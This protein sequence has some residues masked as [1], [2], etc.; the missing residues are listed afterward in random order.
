MLKDKKNSFRCPTCD[1]IKPATD[2][3]SNISRSNGHDGQCKLCRK[4]YDKTRKFTP[5]TRYKNYAQHARKKNRAFELTLKDFDRITSQLCIYCGT[6]ELG[7]NHTGIDRIDSSKGY[8]FSNC[9]PCCWSC[10]YMKS[11]KNISEFASSIITL[12]E[13]LKKNWSSLPFTNDQ[14]NL[15]KTQSMLQMEL[16]E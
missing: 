14:H 12:A 4:A 9:V 16:F 5:A 3:G 6:F 11:N 13:H 15:K 7:K 8:I 2:F 10:N 1:T